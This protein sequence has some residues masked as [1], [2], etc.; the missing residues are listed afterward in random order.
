[1]ESNEALNSAQSEAETT[2]I[3][4]ESE[5][6]HDHSHELPDPAMLFSYVAMQMD[7]PA[8][9]MALSAVFDGH[10]WRS[11][12]LIADPRTGT[13]QKDLPNAQLAIDA[14]QFCLSKVEANL[15]ETE[16]RDANRRL[17]D[18]RMNYL[19]KLRE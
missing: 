17:N 13:T 6:E 1:M 11:L 14:V 16:R 18:L 12:G 10:A 15:S 2:S 4:E 19:A 5:Q 3:A 7:T 9:I 8:L